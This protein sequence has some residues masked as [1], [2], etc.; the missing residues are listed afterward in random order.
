M[1]RSRPF[2]PIIVAGVAVLVAAWLPQTAQATPLAPP[3]PWPQAA[4]NGASSSFNPAE[5]LVSL[6]SVPNLTWTHSFTARPVDP[7][8]IGCGAGVATSPVTAG[9]RLY[10]VLSQRLF[11]FDLTTGATVWSRALDDQ[12]WATFYTSLTIVGSRVILTSEDCVSQSDPSGAITAYRASNG[13][14]V[15]NTFVD[16]GPLSAAVSGNTLVY[17][18]FEEGGGD[19]AA[20]NLA[21]GSSAWTDWLPCSGGGN[22]IVVG[23]LAIVPAC[24][25]TNAN[26]ARLEAHDLATGAV[27]WSRPGAWQVFRGDTDAATGHDVYVASPAG[28]LVDLNPLTGATRWSR[29]GANGVEAVAK[30]YVYTYCDAETLCALSRATGA[31]VWTQVV[32]EGPVA[33]ANGLVFVGGAWDPP[34]RTKNGSFVY[35]G[36]AGAAWTDDQQT[37]AVANGRVITSSHRIVDVYQVPG[38]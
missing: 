36:L 15:W 26:L 28:R 3:A 2:I 25:P 4:A 19:V 34:L 22:I 21:D 8:G 35:I 20:I 29:P 38:A 17:S 5:T 31:T 27:A 12:A 11:A 32:T 14:Q 6:T 37:V 7:N 23:G 33:V 16:P 18:G 1:A 9:N 30:S 13:T 24:N 10:V